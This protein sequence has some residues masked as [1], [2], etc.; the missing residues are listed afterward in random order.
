MLA[1]WEMDGHQNDR[2]FYLESW[3]GLHPYDGA[4]I[5]RGDFFIPNLCLSLFGGIQPPRL[6]QYLR[7]P[8]VCLTT[9]GALQRLQLLVYPN[10]GPPL[11][12]VD[13]YENTSAKNR[14][15]DILQKLA[16]ADFHDLGGQSDQFSPIPWFHFSIEA[17]RRVRKVVRK[18]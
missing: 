12:L 5:G 2:P 1:Q 8:K 16:H 10:R 17:K 11:K 6:A 7:N 14:F 9:D 18:E 13:T 3:N 4:R 15:F